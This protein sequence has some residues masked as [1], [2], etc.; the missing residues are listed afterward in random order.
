MKKIKIG[1]IEDES[2]TA[3]LI[4]KSITTL[5]YSMVFLADNYEEAVENITNK[6]PDILLI[7]IF[8]KGKKDGI[9]LANF[10]NN[11]LKI[12]FIFLTNDSSKDTLERAKKVSPPGYLVKPFTSEELFCSIE[13]CLHNSVKLQESPQVVQPFSKDVIFVKDGTSF[14]KLYIDEIYYMESDHVYINIY[15]KTRKVS[16]RASLNTFYESL[17]KNI[18]YRIHRSYVVNINHIQSFNHDHAL[19]NGTK[20]PILHKY[21]KGIFERFSIL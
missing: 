12:P 9:E 15:T 10:V 18:F 2:M 5:G 6:Q 19:V 14:V 13:I 7:D 21:A 1:V 3:L 4:E 20:V 16:I 11:T 8:L 17:D